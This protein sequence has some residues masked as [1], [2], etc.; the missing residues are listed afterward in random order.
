MLI[1]VAK[2]QTFAQKYQKHI[3]YG[4]IALVIVIGGSAA[5]IWAKKSSAADAVFEELLLRDAY[6][7]NNLDETLQR[8]DD[9]INRYSSTPSA[10]VA[11]MLKGRVFQ[12]RGNYDLA[13]DSFNA[14][15]RNHSSEKYL[16]FAAHYALGNISYG[17]KNYLEAAQHYQRAASR[18]P[19]HFHAAP[20]LLDAGISYEKSKRY[21]DAKRVYRLIL[22]KYD[23]SRS[24]DGARRNLELLEFMP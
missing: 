20:A 17:K 11:W 6:A 1:F 3:L 14:L 5:A 18:Y 2:A 10:A 21:E 4:I 7:R 16:G 23:K 24:V 22:T 19:D 12:Q 8:A 13:E 9:I 15:I